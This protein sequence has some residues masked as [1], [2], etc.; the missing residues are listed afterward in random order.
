MKVSC[1]GRRNRVVLDAAEISVDEGVVP[2][3]GIIHV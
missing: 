2:D 1:N 3:R